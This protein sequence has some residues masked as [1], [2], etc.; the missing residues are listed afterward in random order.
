MPAKYQVIILHGAYGNSQE[1]WFPWLE[2][3][4]IQEGIDAVTPNFPTPQNQSVESWVEILNNSIT[5][6]LSNLALVGHSASCALMLTWL[7]TIN[8]P[9]KAMFLVSSFIQNLGIPEFDKINEVFY[10]GPFKWG[11]IKN[12]C[13]TFHVFHSDNDPY[14]P[15]TRG[16]EIAK[17]L[18]V[19]LQIIHNA[20]H[21]N[22]EAG[23]KEFPSL[24]EE[25]I[26]TL[27]G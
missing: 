15:L 27:N 7:E 8:I 14:V 22:S 4:L 11:K 23:F 24:F 19:E 25:I 12:N 16:E 2:R 1:N 17:N 26:I 9:I 5:V 13:S 3:K 18:G 10:K 6:E 20:G 21:I